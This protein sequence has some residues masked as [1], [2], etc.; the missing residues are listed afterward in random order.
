MLQ[1]PR[2]V[3]DTQRPAPPSVQRIVDAS[4]QL[5]VAPDAPPQDQNQ[6]IEVVSVC[7]NHSKIESGLC[8]LYYQP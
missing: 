5:V 7:Y 6:T 8:G 4:K 2:K 3:F 1:H